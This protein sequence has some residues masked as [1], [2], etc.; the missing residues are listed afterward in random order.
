MKR[1]VVKDYYTGAMLE[2]LKRKPFSDITVSDLVRKSGAS[3]ASFY[4]NYESKEQI[5]DEYLEE[6]F[7]RIIEK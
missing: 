6:I 2:L 4:R 7:G 1:H 5:V 3:R